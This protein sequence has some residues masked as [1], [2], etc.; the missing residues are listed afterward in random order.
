MSKGKGDST[1]ELDRSK[2]GSDL[3]T[4]EE[5]RN[6]DYKYF[7]PDICR[8]SYVPPG[9][10]QIS[11]TEFAGIWR[12]FVNSGLRRITVPSR[13]GLLAEKNRPL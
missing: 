9:I 1:E 7:G 8:V 3:D 6:G 11:Q 12:A 5:P 10:L 4:D 13:K 2:A